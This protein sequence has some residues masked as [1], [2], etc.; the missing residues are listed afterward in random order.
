MKDAARRIAELAEQI[1]FHDC[2]YYVLDQPVL[3]DY[4]YDRLMRELIELERRHPQLVTP[5]SP[6]Q[7]VGG[8][9]TRQFPTVVHPSPMLSLANTYSEDEV[10]EFDARTRAALPGE[11][12]EYVAELKIDGVAV[13]LLYEH[14]VLVRG[15]TRGDGERGDD[16]TANLRTVRTIPLRLM[17]DV[18]RCEARGE[19]YLAKDDFLKLNEEK[20]PLGESPFANPRN[21][22][23]GSLKLQDPRLVAQRRLSSFM[24]WLDTPDQPLDAHAAR[25]ELLTRL[26][27]SVN[28]HRK[29]C[30]ELDEVLSFWREWETRRDGLPYEI[31]G[32]VVKVNH[33][34]Q[35]RRLGSTAKNPRSAIAF[36]FQARKTTTVL[37]EILWQVGR[38]G[39]VT[40]VSSLEP[41]LLAGSTIRRATLHNVDELSR[42]DI[43]VGDTVV[44]EK[45]GD[46][47]PKITG[48]VLEARLADAQP[49]PVPSA[50]PACGSKVHRDED[51]V[52]LRCE[53]PRCP[54]QLRRRVQHFASRGA[55][56]IETL[57]P[58]IVEQLTERGLVKDVADLYT[59]TLGQV[60]ALERMGEKS[61]QN[62]LDGI[63]RSRKSPLYRLIFALGIRHVGA[64][65]ARVLADVFGDLRALEAASVE[66]L[67][68]IPEI[69][70]KIAQ[71][72][73]RFLS[74]PQHREIIEKLRAAGVNPQRPPQAPEPAAGPFAGK[75][76]VLTGALSRH[77]RQ[78][79]EDLIRRMGG[80]IS[81]SVSS[82]TDLVLV[83]ENPGSKRDKARQLGIGEMTEEEFER[84][85][86]A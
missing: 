4:E 51:E 59:L 48:V 42:K 15:A 85:L 23:A 30:A 47:I 10:R 73:V 75:T 16:I 19:V 13:S 70:P 3:S 83:G 69:G 77:T 79:A 25:L 1:R 24:Y 7:R 38:T 11:Q 46:V 80:K 43:R 33:I 74:D 20:G 62:L 26:G 6:T 82:K 63:A 21:A 76:V 81:A 31:D 40:P 29:L 41:V 61:A 56:D 78:E 12:V 66:Q 9:P 55:M 5:D 65:V 34:D 72:I 18:E 22:A 53:N 64:N 39:V 60:A 36:K 32:I 17:A 35:Q 57:G 50:C 37:R 67:E 44:L 8:Q 14:G 86:Q 28:P 84:N 54:A 27:F 68:A 45:G 49:F 71:S 2:R 58:A 52:A